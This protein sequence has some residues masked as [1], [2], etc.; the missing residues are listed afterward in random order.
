M[1]DFSQ[2]HILVLGD[3]MIDQYIKGDVNR[4]SPEAPVPIMTEQSRELKL[5]G[6]ANVACNILSLG[7]KATLV[8]VIGN[9]HNSIIMDS[10]L[11][12]VSIS[13]HLI[14]D[15]SRP[16]TVKTR[17]LSQNQQILR[18]DKE[19]TELI[20]EKIC[21][22]LTKKIESILQKNTIDFI[23]LQDYNKGVLH[24]AVIQRIIKISKAFQ[25]P[26][27]V[28]PKFQ[29]IE[30]YN[31]VEFI[32]PNLKEAA[33]I[34]KISEDAFMSDL[35]E[36]C[37]QLLDLLHLS[38]IWVTLGEHG[39]CCCHKDG[40]FQH[41][42]TY[43]NKIVDVCGAGDAVISILAMM[44]AQSYSIDEMTLAANV[45]G[46]I[47]CSKPGVATVTELEFNNSWKSNQSKI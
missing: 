41:R 46:G 3:V 17:L 25:V 16:T 4:I 44:Q 24:P 38:S 35:Q 19:S 6:A 22:Q 39:I 14:V 11:S 1:F 42:K 33:N 30:S 2:L 43:A 32:K 27:G 40:K 23:I 31:S 26:I 18:L 28:D 45:V 47:V 13:N 5:G 34:L 8:G 36:H 37:K 15:D 29:Y 9:D 12:E 21:Q 10:L 20:N 7:A